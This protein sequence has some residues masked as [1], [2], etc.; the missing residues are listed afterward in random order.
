MTMR[1]SKSDPKDIELSKRIIEAVEKSY[2]FE[3]G[4]LDSRETAPLRFRADE[5]KQAICVLMR[6]HTKLGWAEMGR[7]FYDRA[8]N[9]M[10]NSVECGM[11]RS[12]D[13][14]FMKRLKELEKGLGLRSK[15]GELMD[16]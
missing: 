7:V 10:R 1:I 5:P 16:G 6:L 14:M 12:A 15:V 11:K 13:P 8:P 2:G 4:G 3:P 9:S